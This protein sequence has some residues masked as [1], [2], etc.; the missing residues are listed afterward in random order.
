M[1]PALPALVQLFAWMV[2]RTFMFFL[3]FSLYDLGLWQPYPLRAYILYYKATLSESRQNPAELDKHWSLRHRWSLRA[4]F[5]YT[6]Y[7]LANFFS[8]LVALIVFLTDPGTDREAML[9]DVNYTFDDGICRS[10]D[11]ELIIVVQTLILLLMVLA[12]IVLLWTKNDA[13]YI[14]V[15]RK[16][17]LQFWSQYHLPRLSYLFAPFL[18]RRSCAS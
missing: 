7:F 11:L 2:P 14:K 3:C 8:A 18:S 4:P 10:P 15:R 1:R 6:V 16:C 17:C 5:I 12:L 9:A 13:Y